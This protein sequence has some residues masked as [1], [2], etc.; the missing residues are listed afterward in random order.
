[1]TDTAT[2]K[3]YQ[4]F[5][6]KLA[7]SYNKTSGVDFEELFSEAT[8]GYT[9]AL[10]TY[11]ADKNVPLINWIALCVKSKLNN[12]LYHQKKVPCTFFDEEME[13]TIPS[14]ESV[15]AREEWEEKMDRMS[16]S[17]KI[18]YD[19]IIEAQEE[20]GSMSGRVVRGKLRHILRE[21]GWTHERI[22][23]TINELKA[24]MQEDCREYNPIVQ[25]F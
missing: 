4:N 16:P 17:A 23:N 15:D 7:W 22:W 1:M 19:M 24:L 18:V 20:Y 12:Y 8:V 9:I 6:R 14:P 2:Y 10:N 13:E 25:G 21:K 11:K 3:K 5:L